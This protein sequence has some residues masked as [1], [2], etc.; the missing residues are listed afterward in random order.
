[1]VTERDR[2]WSGSMPAVY[3]RWL[4]PAVFGPFATDLAERA[5]RVDAER[6]LELAAGTGVLTRELV[7][8]G[9]RVTATDLNPA[10]VEYGSA[11]VPQAGWEQADAMRLPYPDGAFD[12]VVCQFGVMFLP[13]RPAGFA[14]ARRVLAPGG[15]L[16][17]NTWDTIGTHGFE[18]PLVEALR[19]LVPP[20]PPLFLETTP[21]GYADLAV[22]TADVAAGGLQPESVETV[23]V[24]GRAEVTADLVRGYCHGTPLRADIER[25]ADLDATT[26]ALIGLLE[27]RLGPG[28]VTAT[29]NAHVIEAAAH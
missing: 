7:A 25:R 14:E 26:A 17:F 24:S 22:I 12:L 19:Q 28:P 13:D 11:Q 29:M 2:R 23:T 20:G 27:A 8:T 3:D 10:M 21:H 6:V 16:L 5:S 15:R 1:M 18:G 4:V 9:A